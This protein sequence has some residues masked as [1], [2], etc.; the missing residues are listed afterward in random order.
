[1]SGEKVQLFPFIGKGKFGKSDRNFNQNHA[2]TVQNTPEHDTFYR[3]YHEQQIKNWE[4]HDG[5]F[6][7]DNHH[8]QKIPPG[9][10]DSSTHV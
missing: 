10:Q 6:S 4:I 2:N 1:M 8:H 9:D 7:E 3:Q 5:S